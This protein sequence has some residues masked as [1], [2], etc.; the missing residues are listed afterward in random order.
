VVLYQQMAVLGVYTALTWLC[1]GVLLHKMRARWWRTSCL[2]RW[3]A[4][5]PWGR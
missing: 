5:P 3:V 1:L 4:L 2:Q